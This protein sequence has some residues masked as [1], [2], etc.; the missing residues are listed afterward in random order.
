MVNEKPGNRRSVVRRSPIVLLG[1]ALVISVV[2]CSPGKDESAARKAPSAELQTYYDQEPEWGDCPA[3][4]AAETGAPGAKVAGGAECTHVEVPMDY[5]KPTGKRLKLFISRLNATGDRIGSLLFNPGGPG[6]PGAGMVAAGQWKATPFV[7]ER[8]D[9]V[10]FDPRGV[11]LSDPVKCGIDLD[12]DYP[13]VETKADYD[14]YVRTSISETQTCKRD[15]GDLLDDVGTLNAARDLD[16]LRAVVG[17]AKLNYVGVSYGTFLGYHYLDRFRGKAGRI[18]L[19]SVVDPTASDT[20]MTKEQTAGF[21]SLYRSF[22]KWCIKEGSCPVGN[23]VDAAYDKTVAFVKSLQANPLPTEGKRKLG[24]EDAITA[25]A[26]SLYSKEVWPLLEQGLKQ[27]FEEKKGST[28]KFI[29]DLYSGRDPETGKPVNNQ[30]VAAAAVNCLDRPRDTTTAKIWQTEVPAFEKVSELFGEFTALGLVTCAVWPEKPKPGA[31]KLVTKGI[32]P[33]LITSNLDD[34]ATPHRMA[35]DLAK[36]LPG[37]ILVSRA[38]FGHGAYASG[39]PCVN[40][41]VD[42]FLISGEL[43]AKDLA[44]K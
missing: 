43:P 23:T 44:C 9:I 35:V 26:A 33:V 27:A 1:F 12:Q 14:Q 20:S 37:A 29:S 34:P 41:A 22:L 16:V 17:D 5:A 36:E 25:I 32:P 7:A 8:Y 40:N 31:Q 10:G 39:D 18:V 13:P 6:G 38:T 24:D 19:D 30:M 2:A 28:L 21:E 4:A 11:G 3:S 15:T 42:K